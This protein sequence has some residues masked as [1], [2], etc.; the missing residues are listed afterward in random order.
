MAGD[1][2]K[3]LAGAVTEVNGKVVFKQVFAARGKSQAQVYATMLNYVNE[4]IAKDNQLEQSKLMLDNPSTGEIVARFEEWMI[5]KKK[6]LNLDLTRIYYQLNIL[7]EE[8]KVT[9]EMSGIR[10]YYDEER[11]GGQGGKR[12][13]AEEW[14]TDKEGLNKKQ[15][16][17]A[18][19]SGK[20]RKKTID[21]KDQIFGDARR[22][23]GERI[24]VQDNTEILE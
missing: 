21:L 2:T 8:G 9:I 12:Y 14:I 17:L 4:L 13:K 16:G 5:F 20:F 22:A 24:V 3:Y 6:T 7:C 15:T 19:M 11:E 1:D 18:R 10:Y 23:F